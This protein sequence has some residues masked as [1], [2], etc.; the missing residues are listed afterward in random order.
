[1]VLKAR[2]FA[3]TPLDVETIMSLGGRSPVP[4]EFCNPETEGRWISLRHCSPFTDVVNMPRSL[5][6]IG[7]ME[8]VESVRRVQLLLTTFEVP[9]SYLFNRHWSPQFRLPGN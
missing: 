7:A 5:S 3:G 9:K 6:T 8:A 1:M 4:D 2:M